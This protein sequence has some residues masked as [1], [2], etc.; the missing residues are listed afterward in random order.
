MS[1]K[2]HSHLPLPLHFSLSLLLLLPLLLVQGVPLTQRP[3]EN[4]NAFGRR[5]CSLPA[6]WGCVG[7]GTWPRLSA[8]VL[9]RLSGLGPLLWPL[10]LSVLGS[11]V[12]P[13]P[14]LAVLAGFGMFGP[15]RAAA[16]WA[17][18]VHHFHR[19]RDIKQMLCLNG[20]C[21]DEMWN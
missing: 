12:G 6:R 15:G 20:C 3:P 7:P 17:A 9:F 10:S 11:R 4:V 18:H 16:P 21:V 19:S 8:T 13:A 5:G 1:T 14:F 2:T